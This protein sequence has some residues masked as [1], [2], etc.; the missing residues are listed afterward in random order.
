MITIFQL[1]RKKIEHLQHPLVYVSGFGG[2]GKTTF[3][4]K[5]QEHL[6]RI[7]CVWSGDLGG[8]TI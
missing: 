8:Q 4:Q 6:S 1:I 3:C 7:I 2:A 5:L